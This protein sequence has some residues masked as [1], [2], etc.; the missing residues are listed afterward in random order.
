MDPEATT[1]AN[2]TIEI[3]GQTFTE[4]NGD[5]MEFDRP[6][7]PPL[8]CIN[9]NQLEDAEQMDTGVENFNDGTD[10]KWKLAN[11]IRR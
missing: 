5:E 7:T 1:S 10:S 3:G 6:P 11:S 2:V 4:Y 8:A 9:V